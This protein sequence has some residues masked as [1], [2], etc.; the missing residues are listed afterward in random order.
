MFLFFYSLGT[1][2]EFIQGKKPNCIFSKQNM[3]ERNLIKDNYLDNVTGFDVGSKD[4]I[5][6]RIIEKYKDCGKY[7]PKK[8]NCEHLATYV[9]YGKRISLQ[10]Y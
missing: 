2:K 3:K 10:V 7:G 5:K 1:V 9:R 8:N 6:E 4:R